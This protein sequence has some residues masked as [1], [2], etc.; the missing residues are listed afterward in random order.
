MRGRGCQLKFNSV[1]ENEIRKVVLNMDAN[2]ASDIPATIMK[3][4][5][6]CYISIL[7]KILNTSLERDCFPIQLKS[8]KVTPVFNKEDELSR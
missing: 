4:S 8:V 6:D 3:D 2:L 1:S 5:V 7:T